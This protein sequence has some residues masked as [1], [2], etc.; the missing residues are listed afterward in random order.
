[1]MYND[2]LWCKNFIIKITTSELVVRGLGNKQEIKYSNYI[3]TNVPKKNSLLA[4][5]G[6][7]NRDQK[8]NYKK[9]FLIIEY[10]LLF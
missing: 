9:V 3:T 4:R 7:K 5:S 2:F 6:S 1:M 10:N 8:Q